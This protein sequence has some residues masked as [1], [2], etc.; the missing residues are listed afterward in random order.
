MK[1]INDC[2]NQANK[3]KAFKPLCEL[4]NSPT[5]LVHHKDFTNYNHSLDNLQS[6][7]RVCHLRLHWEN[8]RVKYKETFLKILAKVQFRGTITSTGTSK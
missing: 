5:T 2:L 7:C 4:C 6:L 8:K 3:R 1:Y